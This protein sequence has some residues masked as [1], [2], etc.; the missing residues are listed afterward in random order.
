M[1]YIDMGLAAAIATATLLIGMGFGAWFYREVLAVEQKSKE[2]DR[3]QKAI[4]DKL[5]VQ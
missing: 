4:A 3:L 2:R 5:G 1:V